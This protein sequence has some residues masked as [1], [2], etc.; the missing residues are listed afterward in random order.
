MVEQ[1]GGYLQGQPC[2]AD[3]ARARERKEADLFLQQKLLDGC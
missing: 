1:V 2:F 3:A